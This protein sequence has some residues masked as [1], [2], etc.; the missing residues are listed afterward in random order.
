M[1]RLIKNWNLLSHVYHGKAQKRYV[2]LTELSENIFS[3]KEKSAIDNVVD[4]LSNYNATQHRRI[5][6]W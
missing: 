6:P 1:H 2:A 5:L 3:E 4:T